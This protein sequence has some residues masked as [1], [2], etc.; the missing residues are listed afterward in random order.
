[1]D[2]YECRRCGQW[3]DG[4]VFA[5]H[6]HAPAHWTPELAADEYSEL[7]DELCI[8]RGRE[9]FIRALIRLPVLD[10]ATEF[11]WGVW[12]SL[13]EASFVR[14]IEDW[15][16]ERREDAPPAF[17]W[18]ATELGVY[19]PGTLN[20]RTNVHT[21]PVGLRPLV[22]LEPTDHPLAIEQREGI[23]LARVQE[24]AEHLLHA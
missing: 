9:F 17:G 18:L 5:Y 11:E 19:V 21:Q 4:P 23:T 1:M 20:L 24:F 13:S 8:I 2:G 3:H 22:E 10:A 16:S 14:A 12:V 15:E 7:S 6:A